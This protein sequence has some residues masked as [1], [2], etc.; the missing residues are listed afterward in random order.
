MMRIES[1]AGVLPTPGAHFAMVV[2]FIQALRTRF[3]LSTRFVFMPENNYGGQVHMA[4]MCYLVHRCINMN[5]RLGDVPLMGA[6]GVRDAMTYPR[7]PAADNV[8]V[9]FYPLVDQASHRHAHVHADDVR[10]EAPLGICTTRMNK[11]GAVDSFATRLADMTVR[12]ACDDEL[13]GRPAQ[14]ARDARLLVD[15]LGQYHLDPRTG[16]Q[17][18]KMPGSNGCDDLA[19]IALLLAYAMDCAVQATDRASSANDLDFAAMVRNAVYNRVEYEPVPQFGLFEQPLIRTVEPLPF[20]R[21]AELRDDTAS[22]P[23]RVRL[24]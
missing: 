16:A 12:L 21:P 10:R 13:V 15:Q 11:N 1:V 18:G 17:T 6:A 9:A 8:V 22:A 23:T 3:G 14:V 20:R 24:L 5:E 19:T 4:D 2:S 7:D